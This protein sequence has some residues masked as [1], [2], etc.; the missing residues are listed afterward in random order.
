MKKKLKKYHTV[1]K[2]SKSNIKVVEREKINTINAQIHNSL[3]SCL[4]INEK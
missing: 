4:G 1:A 3:L 2:I